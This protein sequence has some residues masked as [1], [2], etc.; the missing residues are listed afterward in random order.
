[1]FN[2]Q[3]R[4]LLSAVYSCLT[5]VFIRWSSILDADVQ[6]VSAPLV[7]G[8]KPKNALWIRSWTTRSIQTG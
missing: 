5:D 2:P 8:A 6:P 3:L 7:T 4:A 1:M